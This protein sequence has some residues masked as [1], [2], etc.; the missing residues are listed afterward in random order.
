LWNEDNA[1]ELWAFLLPGLPF[2][3]ARYRLLRSLNVQA[4]ETTADM[5]VLAEML[6]R[7]GESGCP[8][9]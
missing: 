4:T 8:G 9:A 2:D 5:D 6:N 7:Q 1:R 3:A